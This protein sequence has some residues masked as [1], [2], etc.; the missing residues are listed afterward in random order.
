[1]NRTIPF[2]L[3]TA[4]LMAFADASTAQ[5]QKANPL[6][7]GVEKKT[8]T[9]YC[10][11]IKMLGDL[12]Y[13]ADFKEDDKRPAVIFCNGTGFPRRCRA[14]SEYKLPPRS[15]TG[16]TIVTLTSCWSRA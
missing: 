13:P 12:Y 11:G 7:E 5:A 9:I 15:V 4:T 14:S 6:P 8:V 1:M 10:D 16:S 2:A 3:F